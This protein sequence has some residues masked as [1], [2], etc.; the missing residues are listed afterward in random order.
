M[1]KAL[2]E[3]ERKSLFWRHVERRD[4]GRGCWIWIGSRSKE[5]YG[6]LRVNNKLV[7]AHRYAWAM[8][9]EPIPEGYELWGTCMEP[10][11]VN[12]AHRVLRRR[13]CPIEHRIERLIHRQ[14]RNGCW[15]WMGK[16]SGGYPVVTVEGS[17]ELVH[18]VLYEGSH[19]IALRG[20]RI[21]RTCGNKMCVNPS[22]M[23]L[24]RWKRK[25]RREV[26]RG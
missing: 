11:C 12:P 15:E 1:R 25:K 5:G 13:R 14:G 8:L 9:K 17:P 10:S 2:K 6:Q 3:S 18:R 22:H 23:V 26:L 21:Y 20:R 4:K 16:L 24:G 19:E 7:K